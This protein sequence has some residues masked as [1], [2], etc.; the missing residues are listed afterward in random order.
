[1]GFIDSFLLDNT[2]LI[3]YNVNTKIY[4]KAAIK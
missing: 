2:K 4:R 3:V 1:M